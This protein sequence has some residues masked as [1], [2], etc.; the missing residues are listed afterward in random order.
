MSLLARHS[1]VIEPT[2]L[3][4]LDY[5]SIP[6]DFKVSPA[7]NEQFSW[8]VVSNEELNERG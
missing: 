2:V 5:L 8:K 7:V 3:Y 4:E 1:A 6:P